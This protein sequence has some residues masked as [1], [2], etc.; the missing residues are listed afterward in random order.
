FGEREFT[1]NKIRQQ[2][3][4][5]LLALNIGADGL[6]TGYIKEAGYGLVGS[7][8]QN[9]MRLIVVVHG[10]KNEKERVDEARKLLDWGFRSFEARVLFAEGQ[11][12]AEAKLYGGEKSTV[13]LTGKGPVILMVQRAGGDRLSAKLVYTGPVRAPVEQGQQIGK[14]RVWRN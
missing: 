8:V 1:W 7:A 14:L 3:R 2:S 9:G 11:T 6:K 10:A 4:N 12:I 13:E 5:P